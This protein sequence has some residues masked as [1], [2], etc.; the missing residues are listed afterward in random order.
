L[1][2]NQTHALQ[3][4]RTFDDLVTGFGGILRGSLSHFEICEAAAKHVDR[5]P[6]SER[7]LYR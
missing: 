3:Q 4:L 5:R 1:G 7:A 2:H 6:A